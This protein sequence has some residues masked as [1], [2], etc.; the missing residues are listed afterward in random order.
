MKPYQKTLWIVTFAIA[1]GYLESSVVVYLRALYYPNGFGFPMK[2]M[3]QLLAMTELYREAAT[4]IMILVVSILAANYFLQRLAWFLIV[5]SVWDITYYV[6]LKLFLGWPSSFITTDILFLL[7]SM[8]TGPVIAPVINS[9]TMIVLAAVILQNQKDS[10]PLRFLSRWVWGFLVVGC[11]LVL[12]AYMKD[13]M[14]YM[15]DYKRT[16]AIDFNDKESM[17]LL[18]TH[19]MPGSFDWVL[20]SSGVIMHFTAIRMILLSRNKSYRKL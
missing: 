13:F 6:F 12:M 19:F 20:F 9:L 5:F 8:W 7:P 14:I 4:I 10:V 3:S 1:M 15:I 17:N 2:E 18:T 11:I 16:H